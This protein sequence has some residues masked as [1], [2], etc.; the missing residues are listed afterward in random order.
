MDYKEILPPKALRKFDAMCL[1]NE[2]LHQNK[3]L[4][5]QILSWAADTLEEARAEWSERRNDT[6]ESV[7]ECHTRSEAKRKS[8]IKDQKYA[9]FREYL[10]KVQREQFDIALQ[11]GY[12]LTANSFVEW[13][14]ANKANE[15]QIPY[16][17][18][19]Q[20]NK[21]RQLAQQN[22]REFKKLLHDKA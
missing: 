2:K 1:K 7:I 13:F 21:L 11:N 12:K 19:N 10:K 6:I 4:Q 17:E 9:P 20:K 14:L 15:I 16:V 5:L 22:N 18:Q 3:E 8:D